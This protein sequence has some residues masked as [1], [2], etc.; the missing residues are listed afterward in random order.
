MDYPENG[1]DPVHTY[2]VTGA[3]GT[4]AWSLAG[5]DSGLFTI[6]NGVLSFVNSPDYEAPF[7]SSDAAADRNDYL[8]NIYVTDGNSSG[9]IEPVRIMVTDVNEPPAFSD[10]EDGRR[11]ISESAGSNEDI[12]DLFEAEDPDGDLLDYSLGGT[13]ALSFSIDQYS[14]QLKTAAVLDFE[15]KTSYSLTVSVTDNRDAEGND[16]AT[17]DDT[18]NVTVSVTGA[19]EAPTITGED[20]IDYPETSTLDVEDYDATDPENDSVTWSLKEVDDYDDLSINSTTGVLTFDSPPDYEDPQNTD[21]EYLVT[22]VAT[23]SNSNASELP[24]TITITQVDDPPVITYD[25]NTGAQTIPFDEN[26]TGAVATFIAI[27]QENNSIA[28]DKSGDDETLFSISNAGVLSFISPPDYED[29]K[30][31]GQ[32]N[33]YEVTVEASDGTNDAV[34][35]VTVRV[36]DVDEDPVVTGDTGPSVVEGNSDSFATYSADDP[37]D[38]SPTWEDPTGDDGSLF[39]ITSAGKLSFKAAPDFETPGSAAGTN[40]Y[41]VTVNASDGTNTGS[42]AV[43]VAVVNSN[44]VIV[45]EGTWTAARDYPENS[46]TVVATYAATDPEGET[47]IWDLDGNDDDKLS[48]SSA[49]VL[50]FNTVPDFEDKKDHNTDNV[51]EVTVVA[52]DGTNKETQDV[53]ITITNVNEAPVLTVVEEVTF[54]EGGTGTVVTFE[55]TDPDANTTI[56]WSLSGTDAGDFNDITKPSNEP[57][58]G[59]L[60]FETV[61][62]RESPADDDTSNDYEITVTATDEGGLPDE[63]DVTIIVSNEDE[64]PTLSGPT[65]F[66]YAENAHNTAATYYAVDPEEDSITWSLLGDDVALFAVTPQQAGADTAHLTFRSAPDFE[67]KQDDDSNNIYEVTI[68]ATDGNADHVRTLDVEITV[69]D[70]NETPVID[71]IIIDVYEENGTGDVADFSATDPENDTVEWTLS[72]D[73]DAYFEIDDETGVLTFV[74]PPDYELMVDGVQKYTYDITVQASD[75][76]FTAPLPVTITVDN[77]D[78]TPTI[79]GETENDTINPFFDHK[80]NDASPIHRLSSLDPEG[81]A[82]TWELDGADKDE[83]SITGGVLEFPSPP[84]FEDPQDSG[85]NNVYNITVKATDNTNNTATLPVTVTVTN[86]NEDPQ[87]DAET[88][89]V[90]VAENT[91]TNR[92]IGSPFKAT[93]ED[94]ADR[95]AYTLGGDDKD[96]FQMTSSHS[97][98]AQ[99]RTK[100]DLDYED[101]RTYTVTILVRD[102]VDDVGDPNV[103]ADDTIDITIN[104]TNADENGTVTLSSEQPEEE[105][106]ITATLED[107]DGGVTGL[108]W[109][110][111]TASSSTSSS[112]TNATGT[113]TSSGMTSTYTAVNA[114]VNKYLRATASYTDAQGG[115]K[116]AHGISTNKVDAKP[117]DPQPPEFSQT[118]VTRQVAENATVG[119]NVGQPVRATDPERKALTYTLEGTDSNSFDIVQSSGQ[120]QT[121]ENVDLDFE[122]K[123]T[124]T[125]TVRATDPGTLSDTIVVTINLVD[126]N[127]PPG[128]VSITQVMPSPGNEQN[129]LMVKWTEPENGGPSITGYNLKYAQKGTD[130]WEEGESSDTQEELDELLPDTE[131]K[132]MINA[133]NDEGDGTWSDTGEGKTNAKLESDWLELTAKFARSSYSVTEGRRVTIRVDLSDVADRRQEI[134]ITVSAGSAEPGDYS[135][136]DLT[137]DG[138]LPFVPGN[139]SASFTIQA[140]RDTDRNDEKVTLALG[141]L[142]NK[143]LEGSITS[144]TVT[145]RDS[146]RAPRP[147]PPPSLPDPPAT[148]E[149]DND[150]NDGGGNGGGGNDGGSGGGYGGGGGGGGFF[151]GFG[152]GGLRD[153][154][155]RQ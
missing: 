59:E 100:A 105:Q 124:Y 39:E 40:V 77:V 55:V 90:D 64:T 142:P 103:T 101:T 73:D 10:S 75:D 65:A 83:L 110:W 116:T 123:P 138:A 81:T 137:N 6:N 37:E 127:E 88:A 114:D 92:S 4:V 15:S 93:D 66:E 144:V 106:S 119:T 104:V 34:M 7:D 44:E 25:G 139:T 53:R 150:D 22:V 31:Q 1:T 14:G 51:Y 46:D 151:G 97:G 98:G 19:N 131:Y 87:F 49:G 109:Q 146:Y 94:V 82:I 48:I 8:F 72:G 128:K 41:Q 85:G 99:L 17:A 155:R 120:I 130:G 133:E 56:T 13:D 74:A 61:P 9:K 62:D 112:W 79:S 134:P 24:V 52:S 153:R 76:E 70:E 58:K 132:V 43:T 50:T 36:D 80:E 136:S 12:G 71:D 147:T 126:V 107:V 23:D 145:I 18:I 125:V 113:T 30:D 121:K 86:V 42:L 21:H 111:A 122:T 135:V 148:D 38:E 102:G 32:N 108:S 91:A 95:L 20:T 3:T 149:D 96:S 69:T 152:G 63:M 68:R 143:I 54:A 140:N 115:N 29:A 5:Q 47:I 60:T 11:T 28:W 27:D 26:D 141:T 78:E 129:G 16:D 154:R 35:N 84:N 45:R 67:T 117:P 118:S 33:H 57:M 2:T 89:T